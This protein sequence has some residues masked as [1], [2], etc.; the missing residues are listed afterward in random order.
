MTRSPLPSVLVVGLGL[1]GGSVGLALRDHGVQV[2]GVTRR[3]DALHKAVMR[4]AVQG[5]SLELADEVGNAGLILVAAPTRTSIRLLREVG[6]LASPGAILT[7][8]CSSKQEVVRAMDVLPET[9]RAVGGHP[10]AGREVA[11]IEAADPGL[12][13]GATW[14]LTETERTDEESRGVCERLA[15]LCGAE[16]LWVGAEEHDKAVASISHLPLLTA[17]A[18]VL[19][20]EDADSE[21]VWR[22][23]ASGF[24]DSTRLAA[25][26]PEM[27]ADLAL[28]NAPALA[29]AY[30]L[31]AE[32]LSALVDAARGDDKTRLR[33]LLAQA[34][35]RR[36]GM[37]G[38][39]Q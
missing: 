5:G 13:E 32:Q 15:R 22:L 24:R 30:A 6:A 2:R 36:Q 33:G 3:E 9:V 7:D 38:G 25:G 12:F 35:R 29:E 28:T 10:M 26:E 31:F 19:A 14:V 18:L 37:Y 16:P 11:G 39:G 20:A 17:A 27:G 4:G 21:L 8:A 23:A 1:I 34:A